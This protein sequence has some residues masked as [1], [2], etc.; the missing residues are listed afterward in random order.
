MDLR[1]SVF[2]SEVSLTAGAEV[3]AAIASATPFRKERRLQRPILTSDARK[4]V[5]LK[6]AFPC[7]PALLHHLLENC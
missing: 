6:A 7:K 1:A 3:A 5:A 2:D 4:L